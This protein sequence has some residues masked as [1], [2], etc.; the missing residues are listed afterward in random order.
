MRPIHVEL[1][2][3]SGTQVLGMH[4][5]HAAARVYICKYYYVVPH[6]LTALCYA[7]VYRPYHSAC[8]RA[9]SCLLLLLCR[10][11]CLP[12]DLGRLVTAARLLQRSLDSLACG[13]IDHAL[14]DA[15]HI[16][17]LEYVHM[18]IA[19]SYLQA[20]ALLAVDS[21]GAQQRY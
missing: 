5:H 17:R 8:C 18:V 7:A 2:G 13:E 14:I 1:I 6:L 9:G 10:R 11:M 15:R 3:C 19:T 4:A 21:T 16:F 20:S 12:G